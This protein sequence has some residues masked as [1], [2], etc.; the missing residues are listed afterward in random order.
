MKGKETKSIKRLLEAD[1]E[2]VYEILVA[3][4]AAV[5]FIIKLLRGEDTSN[6]VKIGKTFIADLDEEL[7]NG[8]TEDSTDD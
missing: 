1:E 4:A 8:L 3:G 5:A 6:A 7:A 2:P